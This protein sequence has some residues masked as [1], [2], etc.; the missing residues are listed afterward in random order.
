[1]FARS[2]YPTALVGSQWL[3]RKPLRPVE[4]HCFPPA[5][6]D[7]TDGEAATDSIGQPN[8]NGINVSSRAVAISLLMRLRHCQNWKY[9]KGLEAPA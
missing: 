5:K 4:R 9:R 2:P 7:V 6:R 8:N 1:M 3:K